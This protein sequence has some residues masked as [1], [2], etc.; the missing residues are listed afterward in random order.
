MCRKL[1][2]KGFSQF[3]GKRPQPDE[4]ELHAVSHFCGSQCLTLQP[5]HDDMGNKSLFVELVVILHG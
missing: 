5:V 3:Q 2:I 4:M 1:A